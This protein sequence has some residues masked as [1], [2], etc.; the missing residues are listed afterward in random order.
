MKENCLKETKKLKKYSYEKN[1][2]QSYAEHMWC[3]R[4]NLQTFLQLRVKDEDVEHRCN[5]IKEFLNMNKDTREIISK[6]E[7]KVVIDNK[8]NQI[9]D[10]NNKLHD[11]IISWLKAYNSKEYKYEENKYSSISKETRELSEKY[12]KKP[13][14]ILQDKCFCEIS[15]QNKMLKRSSKFLKEKKNKNK[16]VP[17]KKF[18]YLNKEN[19]I[20]NYLSS[21]EKLVEFLHQLMPFFYHLAF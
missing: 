16:D 12:S 15:Q 13:D 4:R 11:C 1:I 9:K 14:F 21:Q 10:F 2:Y 20:I 17:L 5:I 19:M 8:I 7:D 3:C 18:E 6:I